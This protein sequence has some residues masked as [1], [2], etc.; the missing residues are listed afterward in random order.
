MPTDK[1]KQPRAAMRQRVLKAGKILPPGNMSIVD[2]VIRDMSL[3]GAR[4]AAGD[5]VAIPNEFRLVV[6][7]DDTIRCAEVVW[8]RGDLIGVRFTSEPRRA[9]PRKR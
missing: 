7:Q 3:T 5:Q 9:P 2:C 8:R 6:L 4:L 1:Q